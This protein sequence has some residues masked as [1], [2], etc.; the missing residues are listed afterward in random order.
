VVI[1][2]AS[3]ATDAGWR[4]VVRWSRLTWVVRV[5]SAIL[6]FV[7]SLVLGEL[8]IS[9][10]KD[11]G[12]DVGRRGRLGICRCGLAVWA[13]RGWIRDIQ[14]DFTNRLAARCQG[15]G[16]IIPG[17]AWIGD[18][19][20]SRVPGRTFGEREFELRAG[21]IERIQF[22]SLGVRSAGLVVTTREQGEAW[23]LL[24][25]RDAATLV[26]KLKGRD[27]LGGRPD[28]KDD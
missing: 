6:L 26:M 15:P 2:R 17:V 28:S 23:L 24:D 27:P 9:H 7:V 25:R 19:G 14:V 11:T 18:Q 12:R 13:S 5:V 16:A 21:D 1:E 22:S 10:V 8:P 4:R 3:R 20:L